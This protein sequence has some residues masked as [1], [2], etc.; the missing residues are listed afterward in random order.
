[1][2]VAHTNTG[3]CVV[4]E[5]IVQSESSEDIKQALQ[6]LKHEPQLASTAFCDL[7]F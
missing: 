7:L 4:A 6:I 5:F 1:M 2:Y 3:C